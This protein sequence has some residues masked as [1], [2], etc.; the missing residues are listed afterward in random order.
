W[1]QRRGGMGVVQWPAFKRGPAAT[2]FIRKNFEIERSK[3]RFIALK[4]QFKKRAGGAKPKGEPGRKPRQ[5][6]ETGRVGAATTAA[7]DHTDM[8]DSAHWTASGN[9]V[10]EYRLIS[11]QDRVDGLPA[12]LRRMRGSLISAWA[13]E[14]LSG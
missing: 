14:I 8:I 12:P 1:Q 4:S 9:L 5:P 6:A 7:S 13:T 2:D 11:T 10:E 3:P